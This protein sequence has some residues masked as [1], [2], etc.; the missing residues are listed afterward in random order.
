MKKIRCIIETVL[1]ILMIAVLIFGIKNDIAPKNVFNE[2][3]L[4]PEG[5]W[6]EKMLASDEI[7]QYEYDI[8]KSQNEKNRIMM[9][10][11]HWVDFEIFADD[12]SLYRT[13]GK[14]TGFVHLFE[15][16]TGKK[17]TVQ[18]FHVSKKVADAIEQSDFR[19]GNRSGIYRMILVKNIHAGIFA[20]FAAVSG[21]AAIFAGFYM[22]K[23]WTRQ[24]CESLICLGAFVVDAG[25]WI[26]TD[27]KFLLLFTQKSGVI[28]LVSFL[29]FFTLAI[30]LLSFTKRMFTGKEKMF[31]IMQ[32]LFAAMLGLY[33]INYI[34]AF[35]PIAIIIVLEHIL[36]A[37]TI[38]IVVVEGFIRLHKNKNVKLF[39]VLNGYIIFSICSIIAIVFYYIGLEFQYSI[40]YVIAILCFAFFLADAAGIAIYEQI[41]E[42]A[43]VAL[44]A[45][46][47]YTDMMTGLK[48]RAAFI[49]DSSRDAHTSGAVS[50]IMIDANNLKKIN[51]S[52]GHKRGDELL[53]TVARCMEAGIKKYAGNGRCYRVGG[54]EFVIRLNNATEQDAKECMQRV[55]EALTA[56]DKKTDIPISAAMGYSW[57]DDPDK[58]T[59]KL[60]QSADA[61]MY[62]NKQMMKKGKIR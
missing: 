56:A 16:P 35:I 26:L 2:T 21:F 22:R 49:E 61:Q 50:Y 53:T 19:I 54:D 45:K 37:I 15:V 10:K 60:L 57:S 32:C 41:R 31:G 24:I 29:A 59:E 27:S 52:L 38:T 34:T 46:M 47:A 48:N 44:Y 20:V 17:L 6:S 4:K 42:N 40:S 8:P 55:K 36:I 33:C 51:D 5:T 30:P 14:R 28:E 1:A 3:V 25:L 39:R 62:E 18:F 23:A 58:D 12:V 11:T 13:E 43:N 7:V 9:L